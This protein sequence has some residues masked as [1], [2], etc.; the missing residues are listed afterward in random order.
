[1][2]DKN[3]SLKLPQTIAEFF[4][5]LKPKAKKLQFWDREASAN[6]E[7]PLPYTFSVIHTGLSVTG[8]SKA[9]GLYSNHIL[10]PTNQLLKVTARQ[11]GKRETIVSWKLYKDI[12]D[13][14]KSLGGNL[15][16]DLFIIDE[17][18]PSIK[19]LKFTGVA[20]NTY[21]EFVK[22][23]DIQPGTP[24][25]INWHPEAVK[26]PTGKFYKLEFSVAKNFVPK[27]SFEEASE[28]F[29][30]YITEYLTVQHNRQQKELKGE[31]KKREDSNLVKGDILNKIRAAAQTA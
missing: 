12:K 25:T 31:F 14:I 24:I 3:G 8:L 28:D 21:Y 16:A 30:E 23:N 17:F 27:V 26:S 4:L 1:M 15:A 19:N 29:S 7:V 20:Q 13:D 9:G 18:S 11:G 22:E 6:R 10:D 2:S 5:E